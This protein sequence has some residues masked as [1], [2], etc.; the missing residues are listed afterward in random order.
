[1][2]NL[3]L[4]KTKNLSEEDTSEIEDIHDKLTK[5][6]SRAGLGVFNQLVY[7]KIEELE[8][9]LQDWWGFEQDESKHTYKKL[10]EWR[11]DWIARRFKCLETGQV[12][13]IPDD[14]YYNQFFKVGNGFV[15]VGDAYYFRIGGNIEEVK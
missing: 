11:C 4:V 1:M 9:E 8:F 15:D 12:F 14:V 10:Y 7:D 5:L 3:E 13:E 6:M 2:I